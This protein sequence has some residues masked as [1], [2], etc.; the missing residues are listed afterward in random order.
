MPLLWSQEDVIKGL[1]K[2]GEIMI[3]TGSFS[4]AFWMEKGR[5]SG[6]DWV[7][8][9][10]LHRSDSD[11]RPHW[12]LRGVDKSR[13]PLQTVHLYPSGRYR[14]FANGGKHPKSIDR[15]LYLV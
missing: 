13:F 10:V 9:G 2:K 6:L 3:I 12:M 7:V 14:W 8:K 11:A 15:N 4:G 5:R 1:Q